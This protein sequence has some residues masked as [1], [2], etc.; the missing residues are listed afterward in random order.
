MSNFEHLFS[1]IEIGNLKLRNRTVMGP[2]GTGFADPETNFPTEQMAAYYGERAKGGTGLIIVEQTVVEKRGIWS[3]KGGGIW[4]DDSIPHWKKVV[5]AVHD[6]G[7]TIAIQIGHLGRSTSSTI[8]AGQQPIAPSAV[9]CHMMQEMPQR[10]TVDDIENFKWQ[11]VEG[12]KRALE[13]GFDAIEIHLTHGYLLASFLSG[14]TNKRVDKYGGTLENRMRL[15]LELINEV[16]EAAG[17]EVP[18]LARL[19]SHEANNGRTL[20]ETRVIAKAL[21]EAGLDALDI[22]AGSFSELEWEIPPYYFGPACNAENIEK[23]KDSLSIPVIMNGRIT[24]PRQANQLI[25][26][27]R[28]DLVGINRALIAD[29]YWVK[30]TKNDELDKIKRCIGCTRCI[31]EL[32]SSEDQSLKCTVNPVVGKEAKF[33][34]NPRDKKKQ[35]LVAGG[36]PT[37]LQAAKTAAVRGHDVTLLEKENRLGGQIKAAA[38]PP[39]KY[40]IASLITT[41]ITQAEAAGVKIKKNKKVTPEIVEE[42]NPDTVVVATGAEP[43]I[44]D[45]PGNDKEIICTAIDVLEGRVF[46]GDKV[47]I[48]GGGMVGCETGIYLTDYNKEI[49]IIEMLDE[50]APEEGVLVRPHILREMERRDINVSVETK[51]IK[52][53]ENTLL[54]EHKGSEIEI[55][56]VNNVVFACGMRKENSLEKN[57]RD[58]DR[59]VYTAGDAKTPAKILE[60]LRSG[61]EIGNK[62]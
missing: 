33:K 59:E 1:S 11:Y 23:I 28:T 12:V 44:P 15:P 10:M 53:R 56:D 13:A 14:R 41:L 52:I 60:A 54:C 17:S 36:G 31:D 25:A 5:N 46:P 21:E 61:L 62:I 43:L 16:K 4:S 37:G 6:N 38:I 29:P 32:F 42:Y 34:L 58:T 51:L 48:V 19:A 7:G 18:I 27:N 40:E 2:M 57:I 20:E 9:P 3:P 35:V 45:F 30:K 55:T 47:V 39:Q 8:N 22:S 49:H 26:D 24:E 50:P